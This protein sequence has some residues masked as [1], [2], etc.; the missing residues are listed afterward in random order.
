MLK[1]TEGKA[2]RLKHLSA[3]TFHTAAHRDDFPTVLNRNI[4]QDFDIPLDIFPLETLAGQVQR[5][6]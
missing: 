6:I 5:L 4:L 2:R 3:A 1:R